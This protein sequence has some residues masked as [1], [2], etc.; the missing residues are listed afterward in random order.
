MCLLS[1]AID[2][3]P[4]YRLVLAANRDENY[5][6]PAAPACYWDD[7][8]QILAGRD[9]EA[10]GTWLGVSRNGRLAALTNYY[11]PDEYAADK[12]SRGGLI[13]DFLSGGLSPDG[14]LEKLRQSG[15]HYN[16]FG[17][18]F[19]DS[20]R[21]NFY[22]NRGPSV[23][24]L[25]AGVYALSNHH[26]DTHWPKVVAIKQ[27]LQRIVSTNHID[28]ETVFSL[29]S[30]RTRHPDHLLPD[31]AVGIERE[32]ALSS[33]FVTLEEFGTRCSTVVLIDRENRLT[34][35]ERSYDARQKNLGTVESQ[36]RLVSNS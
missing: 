24:G 34:F 19:G 12:F 8:P 35:L 15:E 10:G 17:L 5:T 27:G 36:F 9:L 23:H 2:R 18:V 31:T 3:H 32:R 16:G 22:S 30:D 7:A 14:F 13:P 4:R 11:G 29:L 28:P 1:F 25:T 33:I 26:L 6:R 21:L 20:D